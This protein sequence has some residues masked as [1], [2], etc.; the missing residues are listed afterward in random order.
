MMRASFPLDPTP[1]F[2]ASMP[3][4]YLNAFDRAA[5]SEHAAIVARRAGA[6]AHLEI[7][8]QP[9]QQADGVRVLCVVA[10]DRPGLLSFISAA[11]VIHGMDVLSAQAYTRRVPGQ[12]TSEAVDFL[13]LR[14]DAGVDH[15]MPVVDVDIERIGAL[16]RQLI[17]GELSIESAVERARSSRTVPPGASTRVTFDEDA[18]EGL[19]VLTVETF[20]RPGLLLAITLALFRANVQI[21]ASDAVTRDA[22]VVDRFTIAELDGSPIRRN[23]RGV[24]Q[25]EVLGAVDALSRPPTPA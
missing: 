25:I 13:W 5:V 21:I 6:P 7:W 9:R 20:D 18:D 17:S 2:R 16:L 10:D 3:D 11:L 8:R 19:A 14:R 24:V 1:A 12:A 22:A 4:R 15:A 23:R